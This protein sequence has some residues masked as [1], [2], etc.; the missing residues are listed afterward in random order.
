MSEEEKRFREAERRLDELLRR[1][2]A[3]IE[4][5]G[6]SVADWSVRAYARNDYLSW[7]YRFETRRARGSEIEKVWVTVSLHEG[8]AAVKVWRRAEIFQ[9]GRQSRWHSTAERLTPLQSLVREGLSAVVFEAI[10]AAEAEAAE[11]V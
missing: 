4:A 2:E 1:D 9:T 3:V 5:R 10:R 11:V 6:I 8:D 7:R